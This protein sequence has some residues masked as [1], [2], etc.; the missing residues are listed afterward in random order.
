MQDPLSDT[1]GMGN[2]LDQL[3][4]MTVVVADTGD[5]NSIKKF[6][7]RDATTNPSLITAAAA[8]A[9]YA[10]I[11]D[12][13]LA[14]AKKEAGPSATREQIVDQAIDRLSVEFGLKI[15]EIVPGR[16]STEVDARLS[17]DTQATVDKAHKLIKQYE[18]AGATRDRVLIKIASTWEGIR[19]A[20]I[21]EREG[22]H[23][24]LTLLFGMHQAIACAEAKVTLISPFV[25]RILDWHKKDTGKTEY[26]PEEDPGVVSVTAIYNYYKKHGHKTEVMGASFRNLGE[27]TELAGCD[28]LTIAPNLL[29]ELSQKAGTLEKKLDAAK[30]AT[31]DIATITVDEAAFRTMHEADRMAHEKLDEGIAGFSKA[32]VAL[33]KQLG[34]RLES[35]T[36]EARAHAARD[37]FKVYD[38][39][40]DGFITREEW[41]GATAVFDALDGDHDGRITPEE[42]AAGLGAAF[43]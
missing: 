29:A 34:E 35:L 7:P 24:N 10:P 38:L 23:C 43:R 8:M 4:S 41:G 31:M 32:L 3:K 15:L 18:A 26:A 9:E 17:F 6:R 30:S 28:L 27:I 42:M 20:E 37:L 14:W 25:G 11:V 36:G 13:T 16:V 22:I 21:L 39:D 33:E 5:I 12:G 2:L 19:A 1:L 40:G